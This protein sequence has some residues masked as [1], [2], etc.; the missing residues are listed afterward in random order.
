MIRW[1]VAL[2]GTARPRPTPA[3]AVLMP[4]TRPRPSAS[5]PPELPGLSAAS[6]WITLSITRTPRPGPR[7]QGAAERRDD[8]GG[9]RALEP[10]R[11]ADRD[12]ELADTQ[13]LGVAE[14]RRRQVAVLGADHREVGERVAAGDGEA[15]LA[16]V[17]EPGAAA[18]AAGDDVGGGEDEAVVG[19]HDAAAG[20]GLRRG[21]GGSGAGRAGSRPTATSRSATPETA[22]E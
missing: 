5:A 1:V 13:L 2:T 7:R 20:A 8:A 19:E 16:A 6:V 10:V 9:D 12:H 11:V 22:R 15:K 3:T 14:L 18:V 4:T 21:R 17:G